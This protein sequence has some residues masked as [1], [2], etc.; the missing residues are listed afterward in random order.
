M[1][2]TEI[3]SGLVLTMAGKSFGLKIPDFDLVCIG[4]RD[5]KEVGARGIV[6]TLEISDTVETSSGRGH[7]EVED[8]DSEEEE[9]KGTEIIGG[10]SV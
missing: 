7:T 4:L 1:R 10:I 3:D 9:T 5:G 6:E 2:A 8:K